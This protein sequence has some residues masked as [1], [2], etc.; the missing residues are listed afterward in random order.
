MLSLTKLMVNVDVRVVEEDNSRWKAVIDSFG[1]VVYAESEEELHHRTTQAITAH[2]GVFDDPTNGLKG[3]RGL[4]AYLKKH[5]VTFEEV[6]LDS[7][8]VNYETTRKVGV[9]VG[10]PA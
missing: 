6:E 4:R 8:R 5:G 7:P 9:Q 1:L 3:L 2:L 10:A